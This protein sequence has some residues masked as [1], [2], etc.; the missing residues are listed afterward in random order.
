[1]RSTRRLAVL[2]VATV[3]I[4]LAAACGGD[5]SAG[6]PP[7]T[8]A[9][10]APDETTATEQ[11][12][13]PDETA[14]PDATSGDSTDGTSGGGGSVEL[15]DAGV[16]D[17]RIQLPGIA[18]VG[19]TGSGSATINVDLSVSG[20]G[21]AQDVS[22]GLIL[23]YDANVVE[24]DERGY[25]AETEITETDVSEAPEGADL[26]TLESLVGVRYR[27]TF[28]A[29]GEAGALELANADELTPE[30]TEAFE[31]FGSGLSSA[32][33]LAYPAEP[34]GIGARWTSTAVVESE[35]FEAEVDY[36]YELV[37][38]DG[39]SYLIDLTYDEDIDQEVDQGG[40]ALQAK[41][42]VNGSGSVRGSVDNP[43]Q[44]TT[45]ITQDFALDFEG[46]GETLQMEMNVEVL[47]EN[48]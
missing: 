45:E 37:E 42:N 36:N 13:T 8:D 32:A 31:Q 2:A 29:D 25:T 17:G 34:I 30:Q 5:D 39:T 46:D 28:A 26:S 11:S 43:L 19:Q 33:A 1:M 22:L 40:T 48:E 14:A 15:L 10:T 35:G 27:Q 47:L 23:G 12:S 38:V 9:T 16:E 44:T 6:D 21:I 24:A 4:S 20:S 3:S 18:E 41:G 7:A